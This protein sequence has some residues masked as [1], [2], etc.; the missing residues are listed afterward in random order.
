MAA[1]V[2]D[3]GN[4][5]EENQNNKKQD[6]EELKVPQDKFE[7]QTKDNNDEEVVSSEVTE[8]VEERFRVDRKKLEN[9]LQ[10]QG[11]FLK[12]VAK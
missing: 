3:G 4:N 5:S 10:L 9:L 2:E 8:I 12:Y 7:S 11:A 1:E 6:E